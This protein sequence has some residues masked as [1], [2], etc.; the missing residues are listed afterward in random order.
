MS[1]ILRTLGKFVT[2]LSYEDLPQSV[3]TKVKELILH[4]LYTGYS[5]I[6]EAES[7]VA[8]SLAEKEF[9]AGGYSTILGKNRKSS[10]LGA[11]FANS[12]L[13]HS[14]Q[15]EDTYKGL[16]PG[17]HVIPA[18]LS[19]AEQESRHGKDI[20]TS[21]TAG[22]EVNL[23]LGNICAPY[24]G[25]RGWRGTT[26]YGII[27]TA[28]ASAKILKLNLEE[29]MDALAL[30]TNLASGLM[31]CW[32]EGTSEWLFTSGL[33]AQN[34]VMAALIARKGSSGA[35]KSFEG[36]R[37]FFR[38]YLDVNPEGLDEL[39]QNLGR[40][41]DTTKVVLKPYSVITTI[42]PIIN[43]IVKLANQNDLNFEEINSV[44]IVA[45]P[46]V[47]DGPLKTSIVDRGPFVNKNQA[48]KS[49]TCASAIALKYG[50]V[51]PQT[52]NQYDDKEV[53][54]IASKINLEGDEKMEGF[55][56]SIEIVMKNG[57][58]FKIEGDEFPS[59][60]IDSVKENLLRAAAQ[61]IPKQKVRE[62]VHSV[63]KLETKSISDVSQYLS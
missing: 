61:F 59:L 20:L 15:Q 53:G 1:T 51:S 56:N 26:I 28:A 55:A 58:K 44:R 36:D 3:V 30:A 57:S 17:P 14:V 29:T 47:T 25:P 50:D 27:G 2:V 21:I 4:H 45:G 12:V 42:L 9:G 48:Y 24:S 38:A 40:N 49:L 63:I 43:N 7:Q 37:G 10:V 8:I 19:L 23:Q 33:A 5:G 6:N 60:A 32:L 35:L 13:M 39:T 54:V 46:R 11:T 22:Y 34:G 41:Y 62:L 31:Q 18:V 16:H 52:T